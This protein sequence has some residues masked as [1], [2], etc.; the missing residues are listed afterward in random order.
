MSGTDAS[1]FEETKQGSIVKA[2]IVEKYFGTWFKVINSQNPERVAYIDLFSGPGRYADGNESTPLRI[3]RLA[4]SDPSLGSKLV[5]LF[6]DK[7]GDSSSTLQ[8]EI[9]ALEGIEK[10]RH[11]PLVS[12]EEVGSR[13]VEALENQTNCPTLLFV[14]PWGYKGLSLRL[15]ES[16]VKDWGC[17]CLFFFNYNRISM[18]IRNSK[19]KAHMEALFGVERAAEL[20]Q[21]IDGRSVEEKE[22]III[23]ALVDAFQEHGKRFVLPF[24]FRDE[25][26]TRTS[27]HLIF[28]SKH[29]LGYTLMKEIMAK[30]CSSHVQGVPSFEYS[31][32]EFDQGLLFELNRPLDELAGLLME[33][34]A[35]KTITVRDIFDSHHVGKPFILANYKDVLRDLEEAGVAQMTPPA[36]ERRMRLGVRT[37]ADHVKVHIWLFEEGDEVSHER[38]G[39]G[40]ITEVGP[41]SVEVTF[42]ASPHIPIWIEKTDPE[43]SF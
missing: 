10:L 15:V 1:F 4:I 25:R 35:G 40:C 6:N 16:V 18:G 33:E 27:H 19:V 43:L 34:F 22:A 8:K 5:A 32:A 42:Q 23:E 26:G 36:S 41:T 20:G 31:P 13:I 17:D 30:E 21:L 7:D 38:Y 9:D 24:R 14:D 39:D 11:K 3:L 2:T 29:V 28:V 37:L 12:D